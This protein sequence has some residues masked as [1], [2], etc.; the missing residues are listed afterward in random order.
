MLDERRQKRK[1]SRHKI[2]GSGAVHDMS[3]TSGAP[4]TVDVNAKKV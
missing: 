4:K 2:K 3:K 1:L